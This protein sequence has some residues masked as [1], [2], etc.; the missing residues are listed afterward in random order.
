MLHLANLTEIEELLLRVPAL[1]TSFEARDM[2]FP[3]SVKTWLEDVERVLAANRLAVVS[4][5]AVLRGVLIASQRGV[6]P[7]IVNLEG[8]ATRRKVQEAT[9]SEIL[10]RAQTSISDAIRMT[11]T[12]FQ[13]AEKLVR[14]IVAV[15][16]RKGLLL[17]PDPNNHG[18]WLKVSW[19]SIEN[20]PDLAAAAVHVAGLIGR[21]DTLA[22]FDRELARR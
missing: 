22:V 7:N 12:Q 8:K 1:V 2:Q 17:E 4:E 6:V 16:G 11:V 13:E 15:A 14:Q 19:Q 9:A 10:R 3:E 5:I 21:V 18:E 20:D